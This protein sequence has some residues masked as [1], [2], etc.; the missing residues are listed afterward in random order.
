MDPHDFDELLF[1]GPASAG[2]DS[3]ALS[4]DR[5]VVPVL[6]PKNPQ[7]YLSRELSFLAFN[8]RVLAQARDASLPLLERLRFL[9]I[10]CTNLDEFFEIRVA[11]LSQQI[12]YN[13]TKR[14]SDGRTPA[15]TLAGVGE[16]A[17][18]FVA[19]QY[20]VLNEELMPAMERQGLAVRKRGEWT[21]A[22]ARWCSSI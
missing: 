6:D 5:A 20:R 14:G 10:S 13:L 9:T 19:E 2:D 22:Q 3:P 4:A 11:G 15:E 18:R 12:H 1:G 21:P 8:E 16:Q 7:H 17:H